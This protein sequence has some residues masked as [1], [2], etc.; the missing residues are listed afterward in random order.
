MTE[1]TSSTIK[2]K[3]IE[4]LVTPDLHPSSTLSSPEFPF[5]TVLTESSLIEPPTSVNPNEVDI[6]E[7]YD[8][9][10]TTPDTYKDFTDRKMSLWTNTLEFRYFDT[11]YLQHRSTMETIKQLRQHAQSL[12]ERADKLQKH[13]SSQRREIKRYL[14]T[15]TRRDL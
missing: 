3:F 5:P 9:V 13:N 4:V 7:L 15:I 10:F 6:V 11:L 1:A 8:Y 12:L 14:P 2:T